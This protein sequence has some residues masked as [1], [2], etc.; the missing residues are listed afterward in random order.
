MRV[1]EFLRI[2]YREG[3]TVVRVAM[4]LRLSRSSIVHT[5]QHRA[6]DLVAKWFLDLVWRADGSA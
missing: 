2:W 1:S 5:A 3:D 6:L 4:E